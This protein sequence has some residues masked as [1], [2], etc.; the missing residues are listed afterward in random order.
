ML[1][2]PIIDLRGNLNSRVVVLHDVSDRKLVEDELRHCSERLETLVEEKT[3]QLR[4]GERMACIGETASMVGGHVI[5]IPIQNPAGHR[6]SFSNRQ[7]CI[8]QSRPLQ[9]A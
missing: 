2:S 5:R 4:A 1:V 6:M 9:Q 8:I 7:F 3:R